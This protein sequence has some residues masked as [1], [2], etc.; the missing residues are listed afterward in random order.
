MTLAPWQA[1]NGALPEVAGS[2]PPTCSAVWMDAA[3]HAETQPLGAAA[4]MLPLGT[5]VGVASPQGSMGGLDP[6]DQGWGKGQSLEL[7]VT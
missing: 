3:A 6:G 1:A 7:P 4:A 5:S 2:S